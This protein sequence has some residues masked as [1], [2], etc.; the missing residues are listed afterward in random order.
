M[1][2][3]L[4][5]GAFSVRAGR[6]A[7]LGNKRMRG[8]DLQKPFHGV[9]TA[10]ASLDVIELCRAYQACTAP[11]AFFCGVTAAMIF[12]VPLP[13]EF[14]M[15]KILRVGVAAPKRAP[16]G[17][18]IVGSALNVAE[19]EV[20]HWRGLRVSS[21]AHTWCQLGRVLTVPDLV[22]AGDH[23]IHWN[24]A[25]TTP[26][27]LAMAV[28]V[29]TGRRGIR[30][31]RTALP[32]LNTRAESRRE[33]LLRLMISVIPGIVAN[34]PIRTSGGFDYRADLAIPERKVVIEYQSNY[35]AE[36]AQFRQ[37]MTRR[38]RLEADGWLVILVNA[39]DLLDP[40]ELVQRIRTAISG[41]PIVD[42]ST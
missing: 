29:A 5:G 36:T 22:A 8:A 19:G 9:R 27:E 14:E 11:S 17:K 2:P 40:Q 31:L 38:G 6:S 15:S 18:G 26:V 41:R 24:R 12:G 39:D 3:Q 13:S 34:L 20:R 21:P 28:T 1:P 16:S 25:L 42:P 33:S 7:G 37:D 10:S 30:N 23:L 35:H 32:L 4:R